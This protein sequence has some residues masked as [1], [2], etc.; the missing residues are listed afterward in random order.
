MT[1]GGQTQLDPRR[2]NL[3]WPKMTKSSSIQK[4][5]ALLEPW[6][7]DTRGS[8]SFQI[9]KTASST[10]Q[11]H[12]CKKSTVKSLKT[13]SLLLNPHHDPTISLLER[14]PLL[15]L[16]LYTN[17]LSFTQSHAILENEKYK[18]RKNINFRRY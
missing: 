13:I 15:K 18:K 10:S 7:L 8:N 6:G 14:L 9:L 17:T 11:K 12:L 5:L 4:D 2:P 3:V 1:Q 16:M